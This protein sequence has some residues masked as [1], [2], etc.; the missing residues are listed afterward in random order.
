MTLTRRCFKTDQQIQRDVRAEI[1]RDLRFKPAELGVEVD[2]GVVTLTGTV[3]TFRKIDEAAELATSVPGVRDV[4]SQLTV[5]PTGTLRDDPAIARAVRDALEW[6]ALVPEE[7]IDSAVHH[8]VV[9]LT[10]TV[11]DGFQR[12][13]AGDAVANL[14]GVVLVNNHVRILPPVRSDADIYDEIKAALQRRFPFENVDAS[15]DAG[16]ITLMGTLPSQPMRREAERVA[17]ATHGVY[18]LTNCIVIA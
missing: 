1:A 5:A 11:D 2:G 10:G 16:A 15:V 17:W 4:A 6:D 18:A 3:A 13:M 12:T 7:R 9:T 14:S 8:G